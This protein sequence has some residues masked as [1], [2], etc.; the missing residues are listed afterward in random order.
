[1]FWA[2][3]ECGPLLDVIL[4]ERCV[5]GR[6]EESM[7]HGEQLCTYLDMT[8]QSELYWPDKHE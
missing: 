5:N 8:E 1:M 3:H 7:F 4:L 6:F 2:E